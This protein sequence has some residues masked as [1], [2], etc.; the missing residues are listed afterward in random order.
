MFEARDIS[1]LKKLTWM[2]MLVSGAALLMACLAFIGYSLGTYRKT[3]L[4]NLSTQAHIIGSNSVSAILFDDPKSANLTLSALK[5]DPDIVLAVIY[6]PDGSPFASYSRSRDEPI[7]ATPSLPKGQAE[8]YWANGKDIALARSIV[9]EGTPNGTVYVQSNLQELNRRLVSY[10][11]IAAIVLMISL[12]AA[13]LVSSLFRKGVAE[14]IIRLAEVAGAVSRDK[15]YSVRVTPIPGQGE[16]SILIEAFNE[17]LGQIQN[18]EEALK[19][20]YDDLERRVEERT[21]ELVLAKKEV[22]ENSESIVRAKEELERASKF[23]DQFLSTMSHELR[24]PLNAVMG[25]SEMLIAERYGPLNERQQRYVNHIHS[26]GEHLLRLINDILDISKIEAGRLQLAIETVQ[27]ATSFSE[28]ADSLQPLAAKKSQLL[29]QHAPRALNVLADPVRFKQI[30]MNLVGNA[31]KFTPD[32]G[33][34]ELTAKLAGEVV[35]IEVRDTGPGIPTEGQSHIFEAFHRLR[36]S[37]KATEGTGL[38]LAITRRLVELHGGQLGIESELGLGSCFYFTLP[39]VP[40]S[41]EESG[42]TVDP[43]QR[44]GSPARILVVEDNLAAAQLLESQLSSVGYEV[45][46]CP[47]A[48][49]VIEMAAE[50]QPAAITLDIVMTPVDGWETLSGLKS[51]PRT[52]DI[53]VIVVTVLDQKD[54]GALFGADEYVVKPVDRAILIAAIGRCLNQRG[55]SQRDCSILVVEDDAPTRELIAEMLSH[56]GYTVSTAA[57]GAQARLH[58]QTSLPQLVILDLILPQVNGFQLLIEWREDSRTADLPILVLTSKDLTMIERE[59]LRTNVRAFFSKQDRW[60]EALI[61]KMRQMMPPP[62]A[63]VDQS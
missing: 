60:Q 15:N 42:R 38:G 51:D 36:Q 11:E 57:D 19:G 18:R 22:E 26:G 41:K 10:T 40:S 25:F 62:C 9:F 14:P 39:T 13:L 54:A 32:R 56:C 6:G 43:I 44:S 24:T 8:T 33:S 49:R 55:R 5:D 46:V 50:L 16:L 34:I 52:A 12:L 58:V 7:P 20:A 1:I 27:V 63:R 47:T 21:E 28:V 30:L 17:M 37:D 31:I 45:I 48:W 53:P 2:N 61:R 23:K 59:Y 29:T 35:R 4:R 3:A